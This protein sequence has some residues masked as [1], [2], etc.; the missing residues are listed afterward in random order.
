M[1]GEKSDKDEGTF[2]R[3]LPKVE[4]H[5]HLEGSLRLET[6][7]E[8][9]REY[10]ITLP[11]KHGLGPLVQMQNDDPYDFATFLSKFATIRL[12]YRSPE[13]IARVTEEAIA[14][15]AADNIRHLELLFTPVALSRAQGFSL[16]EVMDWVAEAAAAAGQKYGVSVLLVASVNR[17]EPV[18][19]AEL[20]IREAAGR[21]D[22]GIVG[23]NLAGNEVQ[24]SARPF[25]GVF[26]EANQAGLHVTIHA[27]EW[28]DAENVREAIVELGAERIGHGVRVLEDPAVMRLASERGTTFEVCLTSNYQ[29][30]SVAKLST[31]PFKQ[32]MDAGLK[33]TLNTDDPSISQITLSDE[34]QLACSEFGLAHSDLLDMVFTAAR[35][36]F[37]PRD[38]QNLLVERMQYELEDRWGLNRSSML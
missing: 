7:Q 38:R 30:G 19:L 10:G 35:A 37:L 13:I 18:E 23:V 16:G 1:M 3:E 22:R 21:M 31:H 24:F 29:T 6:L 2:Y 15:A 20:T 4:L 17:H 8:I 14:D 33:V 27:G 12:F 5:R 26:A 11:A 25:A 28:T 34:Y 32:M 9:A 36:S